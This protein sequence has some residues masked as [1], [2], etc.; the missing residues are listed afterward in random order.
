MKLL[1]CLLATLVVLAACA[2]SCGDKRSTEKAKADQERAA[3]KEQIAA[4]AK[5]HGAIVE[6]QKSLPTREM[7]TPFTYD[8]TKALMPSNDVP[9]LLVMNLDD[10][11][12]R[13][14][15][16]QAR[17]SHFY[18]KH[19]FFEFSLDL[20]CTKE[21]GTELIAGSR[22]GVWCY[23]IVARVTNVVR[24]AFIVHNSADSEHP[25]V[26][27]RIDDCIVRAKGNCIELVRLKELSPTDD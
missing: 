23:A 12:E 9:V 14:G 2:V 16:F 7:A 22:G 8:L 3:D 5:R 4:L 1:P 26:G 15:G 17:F 21:Q 19:G 18:T 20:D 27:S 11:G 24:P 25:Q 13:D 6:W 10:I